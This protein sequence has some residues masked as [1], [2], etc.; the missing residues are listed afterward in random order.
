M[1][2]RSSVGEVLEMVRSGVGEVAE[3]VRSWCW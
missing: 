3:M 1:L 2:V